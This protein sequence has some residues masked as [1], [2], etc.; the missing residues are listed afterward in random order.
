MARIKIC[1][2]TRR[3]D[4]E[5]AIEEGADA[6]GFVVWPSS[7][8]YVNAEELGP[9]LSG[10]PPFV[11]RVAVSVNLFP[12]EVRRLEEAID[13]H[14]G[15]GAAFD[16]WQLHGHESP[17]TA[18]ALAP[19]RV[20]KMFSLQE[21]KPLPE[22]RDYASADAF[23]LDTPSHDYGGTGRTFDWDLAVKFKQ[24]T[25]KPIILSGGLTPDNVAE[26]IERVQPYGVDVSTGVEAES[27]LKDPLKIRDFIQAARGAVCEPSPHPTA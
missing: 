18:A 24:T 9:L 23:L 21:D 16:L 17:E 12:E 8:R 1:G 6:L 4:V 11:Q 20:L 7:K 2:L 15:G 13:H 26:A 10:L 3:Q 19:R 5:T 14:S 25:S 27:R 22:T